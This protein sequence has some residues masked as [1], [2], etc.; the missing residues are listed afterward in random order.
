[1][2]PQIMATI[3]IMSTMATIATIVTI[4]TIAI[5][6]IVTAPVPIIIPVTFPNIPAAAAKL[7]DTVYHRLNQKENTII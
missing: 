1:M 5:P 2:S 7:L 6:I 3:V 4:V